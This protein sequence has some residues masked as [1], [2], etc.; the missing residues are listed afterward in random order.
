MLGDLPCF[1]GASDGV[2]NVDVIYLVIV[3][4]CFAV[5]W[6]LLVLCERL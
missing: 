3:I 4:T 1:S 5:T 2:A 6:A